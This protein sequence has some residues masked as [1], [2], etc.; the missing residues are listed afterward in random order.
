MKLYKIQLAQVEKVLYAISKKEAL[1]KYCKYLKEIIEITNDLHNLKQIS[2]AAL[3]NQFKVEELKLTLIETGYYKIKCRVLWNKQPGYIDSYS[4]TFLGKRYGHQ[5]NYNIQLDDGR[6][7]TNS[8]YDELVN[9]QTL[10]PNIVGFK[11]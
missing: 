10:D 4:K 11:V 2:I 5:V 3:S 1:E 6:L 7:I 8:R 9:E